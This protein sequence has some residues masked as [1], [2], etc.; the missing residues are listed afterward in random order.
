MSKLS[1]YFAWIIGVETISKRLDCGY[2]QL[3]GCR[4]KSVSAGL[5]CGIQSQRLE[6][7]RHWK[8]LSPDL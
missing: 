3:H 7:T 5:S 4:P 8:N 6:M 2:V 1:M